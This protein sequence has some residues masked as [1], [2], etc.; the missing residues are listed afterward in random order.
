MVFRS[1]IDLW[2]VALVVGAAVM[3]VVATIPVFLEPL[4]KS[5]AV[6][7]I[8]TILFALLLT[9][10]LPAWMF[11]ATDYRVE[12]DSCFVRCGPFKWEI[13]LDSITSITPTRNPLS[14]PA[15]SLDRLEIRYG[16]G[17]VILL[18]PKDKNGFIAA[19]RSSQ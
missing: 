15:L 4:S 6:T 3:V 18:S 1:K 19:V 7:A 17:K 16:S 9:I 5:D 13:P 2:L 14:S 8:V 10:G 12:Q 11:M